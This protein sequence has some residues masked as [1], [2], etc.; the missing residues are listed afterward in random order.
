M[1]TLYR[2]ITTKLTQRAQVYT[3]PST[4]HPIY[5]DLPV[6][7]T[8]SRPIKFPETIFTYE[9]WTLDY[10]NKRAYRWKG[11][12]KEQIYSLDASLTGDD[13]NMV[14]P[15]EWKSVKGNYIV[16][17]YYESCFYCDSEIKSAG[18]PSGNPDNIWLLSYRKADDSEAYLYQFTYDNR[19]N[20][21]VQ[22]SLEPRANLQLPPGPGNILGET[23]DIDDE[24]LNELIAADDATIVDDPNNGY[25]GDDPNTVI[26]DPTDPSNTDPSGDPEPTD[27]SGDPSD[28]SGDPEPTDPSDPSGDPADPE[29]TDPN[30][31]GGD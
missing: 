13:N 24:Y 23:Y 18:N 11:T 3:N 16:A 6:L 30:V 1:I 20:I 8:I 2:L 21:L 27:P 15:L 26:D 19:N 31:E 4:G 10:V 9:G 5:A 12:E 22:R 28:P 29:P 14:S 17:E 25:Q 7:R